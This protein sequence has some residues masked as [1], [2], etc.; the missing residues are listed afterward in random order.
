M[1]EI[2]LEMNV[3]SP[4]RQPQPMPVNIANLSNEQFNDEMEKSLLDLNAGKVIPSKQVRE[5]MR[6]NYPV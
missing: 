5:N 6:S 4:A 2:T 1:P 3:F